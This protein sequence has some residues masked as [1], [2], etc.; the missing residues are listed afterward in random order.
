VN[1]ALRRLRGRAEVATIDAYMSAT[2]TP[3]APATDA[4]SDPA[5]APD[6]AAASDVAA[7]SDLAPVV[8]PIPGPG[9]TRLAL[10]LI[11][12][13]LTMLA[14]FIG[15]A[16]SPKLLVE[17]PALLVA[18][19]PRPTHLILAA[20]S[21]P[22]ALFVVIGALR[23]LVADPF[24]FLIGSERGPAAMSWM[25]ARSGKLGRRMI[26]FMRRM[27]DRFALPMAFF[28]AGPLVCVLIGMNGKMSARRFAV[29]NVVGTVCTMFLL[30]LVG[31][32]LAGPVAAVTSFVASHVAEL[33]A[34]TC[35]VVAIGI[36][37]RWRRTVT[38][39]SA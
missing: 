37:S 28:G 20:P 21:V 6:L 39:P 22:L 34:G 23:W 5:P 7:A 36:A 1:V 26:A 18:L 27:V 14:G 2:P 3:R 8:T 9:G 19:D 11:V 13:A 35:A 17:Q 32:E 24:F 12:P 25:E 16:L 29:T 30:R 4:V 15:T 38:S 33:T 10:L 31:L